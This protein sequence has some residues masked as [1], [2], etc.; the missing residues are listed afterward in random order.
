MAKKQQA[1]N[2][3]SQ[4][5]SDSTTNSFNKGM[6]KDYDVSFAPEGTWNHVSLETLVY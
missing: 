1:S 4:Q 2:N 5:S 3:P 6:V